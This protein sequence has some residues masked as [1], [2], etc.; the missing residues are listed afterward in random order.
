MSA[1]ESFAAPPKTTLPRPRLRSIV[2]PRE[3]GGWAIALEPLLLGLVAAPSAPGFM[4]AIAAAFLFLTRRPVRIATGNDARVAQARVV[5]AV[6]GT[7]VVV[8]GCGGLM[9]SQPI[10]GIPLL[11]AIP[12]AIAFAWLDSRKA[13]RATAAELAGATVFA[14]IPASIALAAAR[15]GRIAL[16]LAGFALARAATS[17]L[18]MRTFL[19]RRKGDALSNGPAAIAAIAACTVFGV[20]ALQGGSWIPLAWTLG[21]ALRTWWLLGPHA[22]H[23]TANKLGLSEAVLGAAAAAT[24]GIALR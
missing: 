17:I 21:F 20:V 23:W 1:I 15:D 16:L 24:T 6:L 19:R 8:A 5:V 14:T 2:L 4:L 12:A 9:A 13:G 3:H 22:P 11:V 7:L 10:T 18:P